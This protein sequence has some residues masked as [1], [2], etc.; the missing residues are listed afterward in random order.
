MGGLAE[1][2]ARAQVLRAVREQAALV[3]VA[4][5][6]RAEAEVD[7][8]Q[9]GGRGGQGRRGRGSRELRA[10]T[11]AGLGVASSR[12]EGYALRSDAFDRRMSSSDGAIGASTR[13][14][15]PER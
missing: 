14:T 10:D 1:A 2:A 11:R 3:R 12:R 9:G 4:R 13:D 15:R 6:P 8:E 5:E 7:G